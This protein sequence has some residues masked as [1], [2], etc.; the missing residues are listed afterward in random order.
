ML[1]PCNSHSNPRRKKSVTIYRLLELEKPISA[2]ISTF[3]HG[4][5]LKTIDYKLSKS[6]D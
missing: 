2:L 5:N 4:P 6:L 1:F 3:D